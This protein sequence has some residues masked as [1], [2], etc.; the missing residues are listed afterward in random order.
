QNRSGRLKGLTTFSLRENAFTGAPSY[1]T[2]T[3]KKKTT[4]QPVSPLA[5]IAKLSSKVLQ[6]LH[7]SD[8]GGK[9]RTKGRY[10]AATVRGTD[11]FTEDRCD[12]TLTTVKRGSVNVQDFRTRKTIV[13]KAGHSFLA[14]RF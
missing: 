11:W 4:R 6:T 3:T 13:L 12:G 7:A 9:F 14:K 5:Q 10:S 1:T 2:C 8:R